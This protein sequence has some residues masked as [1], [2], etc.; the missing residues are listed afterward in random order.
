[1]WQ[2][3]DKVELNIHNQTPPIRFPL[4]FKKSNIS[5]QLLFSLFCFSSQAS[6]CAHPIMMKQGFKIFQEEDQWEEMHKSH[7]MKNPLPNLLLW[8]ARAVVHQH[9]PAFLWVIVSFPQ[10]SLWTLQLCFPVPQWDIERQIIK[11]FGHFNI[12]LLEGT[13]WIN[14]ALPHEPGRIHTHTHTRTPWSAACCGLWHIKD[15]HKLLEKIQSSRKTHDESQ[16]GSKRTWRLWFEIQSESWAALR[17]M[18]ESLWIRRCS[19]SS[20]S[21]TVS[22]LCC[23]AGRLSCEPVWQMRGVGS[24]PLI[25]SQGGSCLFCAW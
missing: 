25:Y 17:H 13:V 11:L 1:M 18:T 15:T 12:N 22:A 9:I 23:R 6:P 5:R 14:I 3:D 21:F 2:A 19:S 8:S 4:A 7:M 24:G 16:S 20:T 10:I